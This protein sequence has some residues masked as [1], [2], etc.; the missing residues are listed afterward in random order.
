MIMDLATTLQGNINKS[1]SL[2][3]IGITVG[4]SGHSIV[5]VHPG[6]PAEKAGLLKGDKILKVLDEE[7]RRDLD[8]RPYTLVSA[9]VKREGA[10]PLVVIIRRLPHQEVN[11]PQVRGYFRGR[12]DFV[13]GDDE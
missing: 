3:V 6:T 12:E 10:P 9:I 11:N 7:G 1:K 4:M 2:G 5:N 13:I 8:G